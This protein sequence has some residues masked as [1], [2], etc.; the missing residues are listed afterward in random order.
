[1]GD[2]QNPKRFATDCEGN[3]I[4][5]NPQINA[6]VT[7]GSK[8]IKFR[9]IGHPKDGS[10][11]LLLEASPKVRANFL[12]VRDRIEELVSRFL[13]KL[14]SHGASRLSASRRTSS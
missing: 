10:I 8:P 14:D 7:G 1:M 5:K 12:V 9:M 2:S 13:D 3:V 6:P 4:G 11:N